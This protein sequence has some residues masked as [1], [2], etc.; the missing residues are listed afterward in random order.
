[1]GKASVYNANGWKQKLSNQ[2]LTTTREYLRGCKRA[3][4]FGFLLE[5]N[6]HTLLNLRFFKAH[7]VTNILDF[8]MVCSGVDWIFTST[9]FPRNIHAE[10]GPRS[11]KSNRESFQ[12][13]PKKGLRVWIQA[14]ASNAEL[15]RQ[16]FA[17]FLV[18]LANCSFTTVTAKGRAD[19][20][21]VNWVF[22]ESNESLWT[23][24]N[25]N[26]LH[27]WKCGLDKKHG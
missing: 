8:L 6:H 10:T 22:I 17:L 25:Q 3:V 9:V 19:V 13:K 5:L 21:S 11:Y 15:E 2:T 4:C 16:Y 23:T 18:W 24:T 26:E 14:V 1:M 7:G 12:V 27:A 20:V